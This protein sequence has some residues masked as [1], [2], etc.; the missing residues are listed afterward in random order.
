M[1]IN[2]Y[3]L[4]NSFHASNSTSN[5]FLSINW[6]IDS[7]VFLFLIPNF[8]LKVT[9]SSL[10]IVSFKISF[11]CKEVKL[12]IKIFFSSAPKYIK[13]FFALFPLAK[14]NDALLKKYLFTIF[15]TI[16]VLMN[17]P[18]QFIKYGILFLIADICIFIDLIVW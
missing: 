2:W 9:F 6:P 15:F 10:F 5:P 3:F 13:Y 4:S 18:S 11:L 12:W 16:P 1:I 8:F 14:N 7:T 17:A